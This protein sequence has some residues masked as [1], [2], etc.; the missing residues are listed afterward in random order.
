M[1]S[2]K[3]NFISGFEKI[4]APSWFYEMNRTMNSGKAKGLSRIGL[5][6]TSVGKKIAK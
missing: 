3:N 5:K 2:H 1:S 6:N 4:A